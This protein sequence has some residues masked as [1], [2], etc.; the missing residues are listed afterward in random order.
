MVRTPR[1]GREGLPVDAVALERVGVEIDAQ[2]G[3]VVEADDPVDRAERLPQ[4]LPLQRAVVVQVVLRV[5][6]V[7]TV[8]STCMLAASPTPVP[9]EQATCGVQRTPCA[10]AM[11]A[12]AA[13][14]VIPPTPAAS[15]CTMSK[16]CFSKTGTNS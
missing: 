10:S 12:I 9:D 16:A 14:S 3:A 7:A 1:A 15:G 11:A 13:A 2:A 4:Q 8:A 6:R 5:R